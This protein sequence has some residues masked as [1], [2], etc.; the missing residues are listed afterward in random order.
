MIA[1]CFLSAVYFDPIQRN[2]YIYRE[3][4]Y[5]NV[6]DMQARATESLK[7]HVFHCNMNYMQH[8]QDIKIKRPKKKKRSLADIP[9]PVMN[10]KMLYFGS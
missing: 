1:Y 6:L 2:L 9:N 5:I 4:Q 7:C 10:Q 3:L 8:N